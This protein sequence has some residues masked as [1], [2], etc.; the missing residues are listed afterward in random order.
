MQDYSRLVGI[1][2]GTKRIGVARTDLLQ[3]IA[4]PVGTFSPDDILAE[5]KAL[6]EDSK[7]E[8]FIV[9][10]PLNP[11]GEEGRAT[12]MVDE[13]IK[14]IL[15]KHFPDI[16]VVRID[17]RY[18]SNKALDLMLEAGVP[19]QKRKE[20][21]RRDRIAAAIILQNYLDSQDN[22]GNSTHRNI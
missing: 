4:S 2:V 16:P 18:T 1:D 19:K 9:G 15:S 11:N 7:I 17:E 21:G 22:Y 8:K 12:D 14:K 20:K 6:V 3:T 10:W 5:L 13:F